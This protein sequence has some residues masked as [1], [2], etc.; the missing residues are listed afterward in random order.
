MARASLE[1][2]GPKVCEG[3]SQRADCQV[4]TPKSPLR[5]PRPPRRVRRG[6]HFGGCPRLPPRLEWPPLP[7]P[8]RRHEEPGP[9]QAGPERRLA[10]P[11]QQL[12]HLDRGGE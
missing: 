6:A 7:P 9:R 4:Y 10:L 3:Y 1:E 8:E 11:P 2:R 12:R 5:Q